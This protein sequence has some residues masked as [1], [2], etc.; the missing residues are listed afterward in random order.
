[1]KMSEG[2]K[3][4]RVRPFGARGKKKRK[5]KNFHFKLEERERERCESSKGGATLNEKKERD[6]ILLL[7]AGKK[8]S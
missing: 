7:S 3:G 5:K 8:R 2:R 1:L 6:E 4:F